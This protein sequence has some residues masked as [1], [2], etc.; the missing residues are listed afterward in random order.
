[1][2]KKITWVFYL[3]S[4]IY[5]VGG[6]HSPNT[7]KW[8]KIRVKHIH[9]MGTRDYILEF[10]TEDFSSIS[11][12]LFLSKSASLFLSKSTSPFLSNSASLFLSKSL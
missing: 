2:R 3:V 12:S 9:C 1:M 4:I 6:L 7:L 8:K 10:L 11:A 5:I